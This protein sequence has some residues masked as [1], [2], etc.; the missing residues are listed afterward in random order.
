MIGNDDP[1]AAL[2][3]RG[4]CRFVSVNRGA[5]S[6]GCEPF[7]FPTGQIMLALCAGT[8]ES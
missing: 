7:S 4:G 3:A 5:L 6:A 8:S 2:I 1:V